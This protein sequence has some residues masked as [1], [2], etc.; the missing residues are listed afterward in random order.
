MRGVRADFGH[1]IR[2]S[3]QTGNF[4][5]LVV[6]SGRMLSSLM[7][8]GD[9]AASLVPAPRS[10]G[11]EPLLTMRG[12]TKSFAGVP[13]LRGV[14][15]DVLPGE[16]HCVLGQN[17][18]GK[19]TLIKILSGAYQPDGGE[20]IWQGQP[21]TIPSPTAALGLGIATMYQE[22]DVVD[23]LTI[24][25]NIYLGHERSTGG[26]LH[27]GAANR[28]ARELLGRLGP[29]RPQPVARGRHAVRGEQADREHGARALP[30]H[31]AHRHGRA[32]RR[33]RLRRGEE[34]V[35]RRRGTDVP[36][37][38]RHL[39][40]APARGD[41]PDRRPHHGH[42]GRQQHGQRPPGLGHPDDGAHPADDRPQRRA[43]LPAATADPGRRPRRA[44]CRRARPARHLRRRVVH[45]ARRGSGRARRAGRIGSIRDP[46][47]RLRR[48]QGERG[49]G[50]D[51]GEAA[52]IRFGARRGEPRHRALPRGA[53][54]SGAAARGAG[55]QERHPLAPSP[56]SPVLRCSTSAASAP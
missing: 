14:D 38:R 17:G 23:G 24:A 22:L 13:A 46:R 48:A 45:G 10:L 41:P 18:A 25:E 54:E 53:Q 35:P 50:L 34:P 47:D 26:V 39:H 7:V 40:L 6:I 52:A 44:G 37:D 29:R 4:F 2:S 9:S 28:S 55:L 16:V 56:G 49:H 32:E 42:Q 12:I 20:I 11:T 31:P 30:R 36:G 5:L 43:C 33:A 21:A 15:L 51:R 8:K 27:T 19:S 3:S 1:G